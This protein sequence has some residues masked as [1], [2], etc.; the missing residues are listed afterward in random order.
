MRVHYLQHVPFEGLGVIEQWLASKGAKVSV[1]QL[2][3]GDVLPAASDFD[4][5]IVMGGPMSVCDVSSHPWL[6]LEQELIREA[7]A[8]DKVV[9]GICLGAQLIASAQ[10][11]GV[12][13]NLTPEIGWF[14]IEAVERPERSPFSQLLESVPEVLHW[15]GD[16]FEIP[17]AAT[18]LAR[19][20]G[21][22]RQAF[23]LGDRVLALQ[24]HLE[25][26]RNGLGD[27]VEHCRDELREG[28]WIQ[29][30]REMLGDEKR[31]ERANELMRAV[32]DLLYQISAT[33]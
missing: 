1:S 30:E 15:H 14:R 21:C 12:F 27:L 23:L 28:P 18:H 2:F 24:F 17:P 5:L 32:L 3:R 22:E 19:S 20:E 10:G 9:L 33:P 25:M 4:W 11:A 29:S 7:I 31:F 13:R 6:A 26:T 8:A 16:T